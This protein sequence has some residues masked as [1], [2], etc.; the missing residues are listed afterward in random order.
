MEKSTFTP[1]Y[2]FLRGELVNARTRAGLT[3]RELAK[4]LDVPHSW[5]AKVESGERRLDFVELCWLL[6]AC[7][8]EPVSFVKRALKSFAGV[9]RRRTEA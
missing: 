1:E 3:Q 5:V 8:V 9:K 4:R 6:S 2:T 7:G